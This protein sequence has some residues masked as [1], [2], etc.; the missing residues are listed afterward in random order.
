MPYSEIFPVPF[1]SLPPC[2]P[3]LLSHS[4]PPTPF[5]LFCTPRGEMKRFTSM[6]VWSRVYLLVTMRPRC[7]PGAMSICLIS[8]AL[9][10]HVY[11]V[12]QPFLS[13]PLR[14]VEMTNVPM[15]LISHSKQ[16]PTL[17]PGHCYN[18]KAAFLFHDTVCSTHY[19]HLPT[20]HEYD[21]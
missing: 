11:I 3:P 18:Q 15:E 7:V 12:T 8:A 5:A 9:Y 21:I 10:M 19:A 1:M 4:P 6:R 20:T 14:V 2:P 17:L 16:Q 13:A